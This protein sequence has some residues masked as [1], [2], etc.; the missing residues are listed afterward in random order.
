MNNENIN[1]T[2]ILEIRDTPERKAARRKHII[3]LVAKY[4]VAA[5]LILFF[6]FPYVFMVLKS[7]MSLNETL[8]GEMVHLF[9]KEFTFTN[10]KIVGRFFRNILNT[11]IVIG[12]NAV[13][14]PLSACVVAYPLAR[15]DFTGKKVM[16]AII[17]G[18]VMIPSPVLMVPQYVLYVQ[19]HLTDKLISL[20]IG[21]FW[22]GGALN[23]FLVMQFMRAFPKEMDNAAKIDGANEFQI[24][25]KI[26]FPLCLNVV[27]FMA[28]TVVMGMWMD[29]QGPLIYLRSESKFTVGLAFYY[30]YTYG[31]SGNVSTFLSAQLMAMST[32]MSLVPITLF[33]FFQ[34]TMIGGIKIGAIKG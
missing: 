21:A 8:P 28:I 4:A 14:V 32:V 7:F 13:F 25:G 1:T 9:P 31:E 3:Y 29:F 34:K 23:I 22:G 2:N 12:V 10:Y 6:V 17:M 26:I 24:F 27:V 5:V 33:L 18:T 30:Y 16:F 11:L 15:H 19:M 20:W